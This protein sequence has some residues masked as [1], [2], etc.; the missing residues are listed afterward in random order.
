[1]NDK[2]LKQILQRKIAGNK[3]D[4]HKIGLIFEG[5]GMRGVFSSGVACGLEELGLRDCFDIIY[6]SSSGSCAATYLLSGKIGTG[7]AI[8]YEDLNNFKFIKPWRINE[9][10]DID[11]LNSIFRSEKRVFDQNKVKANKT[12]LKIYVSDARTGKYKYFTNRDNVDLVTAMTASCAAPGYYGKTVEI[13]NH[14]Y[15]DGNVE[16]KLPIDQAIK[17]GCTDILVVPTVPENYR[18]KESTHCNLVNMY[19]MRH[20][21]RGFIASYKERARRYNDN[22]DIA[23]G[24]KQIDNDVNV[25]TISPKYRIGLAQ[26]RARKVEFFSE[27]GK[28]LV[29]EAFGKVLS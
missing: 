16:E 13:N 14:E 27:H 12:L 10:M 23:F 22:L 28:G 18:E 19:L 2:V 29:K 4:G 7:N 21:D 25:F 15:L 24:R 1:M 6:G 20:L 17:D 11:Y 5:G 26:T 8:Y 9:L 3:D